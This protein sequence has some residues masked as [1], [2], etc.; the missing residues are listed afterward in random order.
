[1]DLDKKLK[2]FEVSK[3]LFER[4][5]FK[6]TT[7]DEIAAGASISK[8]TLYEMFDSKEKIL[9]EL[10]IHEGIYIERIMQKELEGINDPL[11]KLQNFTK[12]AMDYF[13]TNPFLS[14][15]MGNE[16]GLY[17]PFLKNE[18]QVIEEGIERFYLKILREGIHKGVFRKMDEKASANCIFILFR[19]FTYTNTLKPNKAW[20]Q[21]ILNAILLPEAMENIDESAQLELEFK[22]S[23]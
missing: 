6:K 14:K 11:Q 17:A 4:F 22:T 12:M 9:S 2:V 21:F 8:R 20:I 18:I 13:S 5:G 19:S 15:V 7:V 10:V 3:E 16:S 23:G 1:M